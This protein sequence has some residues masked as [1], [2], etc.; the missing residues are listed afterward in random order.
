MVPLFF[1]KES[2]AGVLR[3]AKP[4]TVETNVVWQEKLSP[5]W[6][7]IAQDGFRIGS[8]TRLRHITRQLKSSACWYLQAEATSESVWQRGTFLGRRSFLSDK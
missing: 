6:F 7:S 5:R 8:H 2:I 1:V 4:I 3:V